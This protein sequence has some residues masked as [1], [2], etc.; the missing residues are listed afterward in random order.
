MDVEGII[1]G[2]VGRTAMAQDRV[3]K[4]TLKVTGGAE[5]LLPHVRFSVNGSYASF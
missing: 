4:R 5:L 1:S 2:Y 3:Q